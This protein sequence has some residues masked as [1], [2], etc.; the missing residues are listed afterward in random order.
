MKTTKQHIN[1]HMKSF[2]KYPSNPPPSDL[3]T[4]IISIESNIKLEINYD[5]FLLVP[6]DV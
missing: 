5:D 2:I 6:V 1:T 4:Q 3:N